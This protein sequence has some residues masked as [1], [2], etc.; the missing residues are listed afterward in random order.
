MIQDIRCD[1]AGR[2]YTAVGRTPVVY[3]LLAAYTRDSC[4]APFTV[5]GEMEFYHALH[6]FETV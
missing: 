1:G 4:G 6:I 5:E 2:I 3:G